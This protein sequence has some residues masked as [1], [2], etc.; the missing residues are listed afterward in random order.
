MHFFCTSATFSVPAAD[1][2][3]RSRLRNTQEARPYTTRKFGP[4]P[5][6][7]ARS[8]RSKLRELASNHGIASRRARASQD[9]GTPTFRLFCSTEPHGINTRFKIL[10]FYSNGTLL[11]V[12]GP[13]PC[14]CGPLLCV[15]R[16]LLCVCVRVCGSVHLCAGT[17]RF[18]FLIFALLAPAASHRPSSSSSLL[19]GSHGTTAVAHQALSFSDGR[20]R[21]IYVCA[22]ACHVSYRNITYSQERC[23]GAAQGA[24]RYKPTRSR[25]FKRKRA[26][27]DT[28]TAAVRQPHN[29]TSASNSGLWDTHC[30]LLYS[31]HIIS[32]HISCVCAVFSR[33]YLYM[34]SII[35]HL[36]ISTYNFKIKHASSNLILPYSSIPGIQQ[37]PE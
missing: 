22:C 6:S 2:F 10:P 29:S 18:S 15:C 35:P 27:T 21:C 19:C 23:K 8:E 24:G 20:G 9:N 16:H 37:Y 30:A 1:L 34:H 26:A 4:R 5:G 12:C 33:R 3:S 17:P 14:V 7:V 11:C 32:Y 36:L 31:Y 13:L 25:D 28:T